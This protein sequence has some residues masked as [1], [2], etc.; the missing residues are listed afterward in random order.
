MTYRFEPLNRDDFPLIR[1]WL[2]QPHIGGWWGDGPTETALMEADFDNPAIAMRLVWYGADPI[3]YLQDYDTHHW[4][5]PHYARFPKGTRAIDTFLGDP[6]YLGRGHAARY[7]NQ[8]ARELTAEGAPAIVVDP[9]PDNT[10][11]IAAYTRAG[12]T[13]ERLAPCEDGDPVRIMVFDRR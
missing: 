5:M 11:A 6:A 12:F 8:R 10:R 2:A 3:A 9:A 1:H 7:L 13:G 4:P